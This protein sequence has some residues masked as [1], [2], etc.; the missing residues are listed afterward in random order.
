MRLGLSLLILFVNRKLFPLR[1]G[2]VDDWHHRKGRVM[3]A[4]AI[5][6][7]RRNMDNETIFE[8]G[9]ATYQFFFDCIVGDDTSLNKLR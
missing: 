9:P 4:Y 6:V 3:L 7:E 5:H 1:L 8:I 2:R